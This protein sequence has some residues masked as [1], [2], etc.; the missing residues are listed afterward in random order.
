MR[1]KTDYC[2]V[3]RLTH[4]PTGKYYIGV[5]SYWKNQQQLPWE[6]LGHH[7]FTSSTVVRPLYQ[8]RP[9]DFQS[10]IIGV[11]PT[12]PKAW[13]FEQRLLK[14]CGVPFNPKFFNASV[15]TVQGIVTRLGT[16]PLSIHKLDKLPV[17]NLRDFSRPRLPL[18][19]SVKSYVLNKVEKLNRQQKRNAFYA[20]ER[21]RCA[22]TWSTRPW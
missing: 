18:E 22:D 12:Y 13:L 17:K 16:I 3:Y 20:K 21:K 1:K 11:F 2:Y 15:V 8:S 14:R 5:R 19:I 4:I 6:D 10:K 7:Y 9:Q